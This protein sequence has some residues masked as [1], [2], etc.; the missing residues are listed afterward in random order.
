MSL[1]LACPERLIFHP[2]AAVSS[3]QG[4][5]PG[6]SGSDLSAPRGVG[7]AGVAGAGARSSPP[8]GGAISGVAHLD[9]RAAHLEGG[10]SPSQPLPGRRQP[11][12]LGRAG[13]GKPPFP[14]Q[15]GAGRPLPG[16]L[17]APC[18]GCPRPGRTTAPVGPCAPPTHPRLSPLSLPPASREPD[19][20]ARERG[21]A[22]QGR[23]GRAR[24]G[25]GCRCCGRWP[26]SGAAARWSWA[27]PAPSRAG[28]R[29]LAASLRRPER[30]C[31]RG[32]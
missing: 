16:S 22:R 1:L 5:R 20:L 8:G 2:S 10:T 24:Q 28:E 21:A 32:S 18:Y 14:R 11:R 29:L 3:D 15:L 30:S 25:R 23:Q 17:P 26:H 19:R 7:G 12:A 27:A 4:A 31:G 9:L 13:C 6:P